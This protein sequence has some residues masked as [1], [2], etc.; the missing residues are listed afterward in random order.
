M[1][2][3][4]YRDAT[5]A[6]A[7]ALAFL[8]EQSFAETFGHLYRPED[9]ASFLGQLDEAGWRKELADPDLA[10]RIAEADGVPVGFAKVGPLKLPVDPRGPSAELRQLYVLKPWQGSGIARELMAWTLAEARRRAAE[11]LYLTVYV[12]NHRARRFYEGYG[13]EF[14]GPYKFM[15]GNQADEDHIMRLALGA[16]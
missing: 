16:K 8:F 14:V 9:L 4:D 1:K 13:F 3:T 15:V 12:D 10:I 2:A 6:D 7:K 5:K 11:H